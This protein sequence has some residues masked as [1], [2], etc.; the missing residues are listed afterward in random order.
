MATDSLVLISDSRWLNLVSGHALNLFSV[1]R[2]W[3]PNWEQKTLLLMCSFVFL[4]WTIIP[5]NE[6]VCSGNV[7]VMLISAFKDQILIKFQ[8]HRMLRLILHEGFQQCRQHKH[9]DQDSDDHY[10]TW[11]RLGLRM[12][13]Y[14]FQAKNRMAK[15]DVTLLHQI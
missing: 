13:M 12:R 6:P 11:T 10:V 2:F 3:P 14:I 15:P 8:S 4:S 5:A 1:T 7:I 9:S